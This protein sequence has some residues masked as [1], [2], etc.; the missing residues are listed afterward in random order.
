MKVRLA[1]PIA[2]L[3]TGLIA[4]VT[5]LTPMSAGATAATPPWEPDAN[6]SGTINFYDSSGNQIS[7][8]KITDTPFAAYAVG[9]ALPRSGDTGAILEFSQPNPSVTNSLNWGVLGITALAT[10]FPVKGS[11]VPSS[12]SSLSASHPVVKGAATDTSLQNDVYSAPNTGP[13]GDSF[14]GASGCA[15]STKVSGCTNATYQNLYQIRM[16]ST[17]GTDNSIPFDDADILV[18]P[19]TGVWTQ[20]YPTPPVAA[21]ST[22]TVVTTSP[23]GPTTHGTSVTL[24]ATVTASDATKPAGS[25]QFEVDGAALGAAAT[26]DATTETATLTTSALAAGKHKLTAVFQATDSADYSGSTSPA[27]TF[28]V[29]PVAAKPTISGTIRAGK[30]VTCNEPTALGEAASFEWKLTGK[31]AAAGR[32]FTLPG[33]AVGKSL[34]CTATLTV[35]GGTPSSATSVAKKVALGAALR[36]TKKPTLTG[37]GKVGAAEKASP[38]KWSPRASKYKYQWYLGNAKIKG[39]TKAT[40][41]PTSKDSGKKLSCAVTAQKVG[42]AVGTAKSKSIKVK[43]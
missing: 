5:A 41:K 37:G 6:A 26:V 22:T 8:G 11:G 13:S 15:Y 31:N 34:T 17:N 12:I 33:A 40:F 39:A 19:A 38:G 9:S 32:T 1:R 23:A 10:A 20:V 2:V 29:N 4:V 7:T 28:L 27:V 3:G 18:D 21:N 42:F 35:S 36:A 43:P 24:T 14:D 16:V 30:V 25:V